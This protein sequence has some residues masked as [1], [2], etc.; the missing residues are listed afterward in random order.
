MNWSIG[1]RD[2][3]KVRK[4]LAILLI[5]SVCLMG[6]CSAFGKKNESG[7]KPDVEEVSATEKT[8]HCYKGDAMVFAK[9]HLPEG[10]PEGDG[11]FPVV[12][13]ASGQDG[14]YSY[15]EDVALALAADGIAAA[16]F[17]YSGTYGSLSDGKYGVYS[18]ETY[19]ADIWCVVEGLCT[20]PYIDADNVFLWGHSLGGLAATHL[21]NSHPDAIKGIIGVE[22]SYQLRDDVEEIFPD[23]SDL[24]EVIYDPI[25]TTKLYVEDILAFDIYEEIPKYEH[26]VLII[27]GNSSDSI[28]GEEMEY[29]ERADE[30]F[31]SSEMV[32]VDG[33]SHT[34]TGE[35]RKEMI[36][37]TIAFVKENVG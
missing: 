34:F 4:I 36:N 8:L 24:K 26:N 6:G 9:L 29:M 35:Y 19:S 31:Q 1:I 11:K 12:V 10:D 14:R 25:Y 15:D 18:V 27:L 20:L 28:G 33:A 3:N 17:D 23:T 30:L 13:I 7:R 37:L 21:T 2:M 5:V 16:V 22:P 32:V